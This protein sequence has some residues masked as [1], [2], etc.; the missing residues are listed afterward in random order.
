MQRRTPTT[1]APVITT[2]GQPDDDRGD[3]RSSCRW[4][5]AIASRCSTTPAASRSTRDA[6]R[7]R[8][9][10]DARH[11]RPV[12]S[13][14]SRQAVSERP[15]GGGGG[16]GARGSHDRRLAEQQPGRRRPRASTGSA[17]TPKGWRSGP[18]FSGSTPPP[19]ATSSARGGDGRRRQL[20]RRLAEHNQDGGGWR[21]LTASATTPT[22]RRRA[23]SS[24]STPTRPVTSRRR[25]SRSTRRA[26]SSS[27]GRAQDQDGAGY[28]IYGQRFDAGG[29]AQGGE[30][31]VN[32]TTA[33]E[34]A[35]TTRGDARQTA[36]SS[37]PSRA[38]TPG[39]LAS[40]VYRAALSPPT[41]SAQGGESR[42]NTTTVSTAQQPIPSIAADAA[43]NFV[44]VWQSSDADV[45]RHRH[46][47]PALRCRAAAR[48]A[49]SSRS[50][51]PR[52]TTRPTP[53][54]AMR[55]AGGDF[56]VAWQAETRT[57]RRRRRRL[58]AALT[59][60]C[61]TTR[62]SGSTHADVQTCVRRHVRRRPTLS[63]PMERR[64]HRKAR[65]GASSAQ[66]TSSTR[67][68]GI[69]VRQTVIVDASMTCTGTWTAN[70]VLDGWSSHRS[71]GSDG[72]RRRRTSTTLGTAAAAAH[73]D[74]SA[75]W[76][77]VRRTT[78]RR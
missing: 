32:T 1:Q 27:S 41:A 59:R 37:S 42:V 24:A 18:E 78:T 19:P 39:R 17:S 56:I 26:T 58:H 65:A 28:G 68:T 60:P 52:P 29:T 9:H 48:W 14:R 69:S 13:S 31:R 74:S 20:R 21:H 23:A 50:T 22:A 46:L 75:T 72:E 76:I 70:D 61:T 73:H 2:A 30:F 64:R 16:D 12:A 77:D 55:N 44:V 66:L 57:A 25:R 4:P 8:R 54:V 35:R 6:D 40:G 5:A 7:D 47:R 67:A 33:K 11:Q 43:G 3:R 36:A 62:E 38:A 10:A 49:A 53:A 15:A 63:S 45:R 71:A 51:R 34:P